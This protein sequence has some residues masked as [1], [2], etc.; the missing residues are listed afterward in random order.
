MASIDKVYKLT[1]INCNGLADRPKRIQVLKWAKKHF[2]G[3]IFLQETHTN[4]KLEGKWRNEAGKQYHLFFSHASSAKCG[5]CIL[6]PKHLL[7]NVIDVISDEEGRL[8][9][10]QLKM[11]NV[12]YTLC[13]VYAP[14]KESQVEQVAFL[15]KLEPYLEKFS[16]TKLLIGGDFNI[17]CNP[18]LDKYKAKD[19]ELPSRASIRLNDLKKQFN[20][21][22]IWRTLNPKLI[23]FTWRRLNPLQQ[24]RLDYWLM[25][26]S[27]IF[28]VKNCEIGLSFR[29]DHNA[30]YID[31]KFGNPQSRGKGLWKMNNSLLKE[32]RYIRCI[33]DLLTNLQADLYLID[34]DRLTWEY[35][36]MCI[37]RETIQ[38]SINRKKRLEQERNLLVFE[39]NTL[40]IKISDSTVI[41]ENDVYLYQSLKKDLDDLE[42]EKINGQ[43]LRSKAQWAEEGERSS[44]F[45]LNLEKHNYDI[46]HITMLLSD[47]GEVIEGSNK[48]QEELLRFYQN[49]YTSPML[50]SEDFTDYLPESVLNELDTKLLDNLISLEECKEALDDLPSGKT[51][52]SD[53]LTK[54]FYLCFWEELGHLFYLSL[55]RSVEV[56]EL[57]IE[58]R[59]GVINLLP[60]ADKDL[61]YIKNW[62]PISI[63]NVDYKIIAKILANRMSPIL[64]QLINEDQTGYVMNRLMGENVRV[65]H[66]LMHC[67]D[68]GIIEGVLMLVDFQKAFDSLSWDFL[69]YT[70]EV[71]GFGLYFRNMVKLLYTNITGSVINNGYCTKFFQL[72]RGIRQ[73]CPVSAYL[74]ILCVELLA[75]KIRA[76][77]TIKGITIKDYTY[78]V[79]QFAD[80]TVIITNSLEG[81]RE[82][83]RVL[84]HFGSVSGLVI[85]KEK[86]ELINLSNKPHSSNTTFGLTW[87]TTPFRYLGIWFSTDPIQMEYKN[88]RH[89]LDKI[90]NLLK[91][92]RQRD[93]SLKGKVTILRS[94]AL[95]QL[96]FPMSL[97]DCPLW[98]MSEANDLFFK[99]LWSDKPDKIKRSTVIRGIE[100]GG[101]KMID[102][103]TM[104]RAMKAKWCVK[105]YADSQKKW[106]NIA[107]TFFDNI[108]M[109]MF[110]NSNY[111][112]STIPNSLPMFYKQCLYALSEVKHVNFKDFRVILSQSLWFNKHIRV[113]GKPVFCQEWYNKGLCH[114]N[115]LIGSDGKFQEPQKIFEKFTIEATNNNVLLFFSLKSAIPKAWKIVLKNDFAY[116]SDLTDFKED[117]MIVC[118]HIERNIYFVGNKDIYWCLIKLKT[119]DIVTSQYMWENDY[120]VTAEN[121]SKYNYAPYTYVRDCKIQSM[122]YKI[123]HNVY[124]C[125]LKLFQYK[126]FSDAKCRDCGIIDNLPHHFYYCKDM[127]IF[128]NSIN[129]WWKQTCQ[130]CSVND[131]LQVL[132]GIIDKSCH[133]PQLNYIILV[134][135]WYV[136]R[137]KYLSQK[138][139]FLEFLCELKTR[140]KVEEKVYNNNGKSLKF[141][142][143]WHETVIML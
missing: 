83:L 134:A 63:L 108:P 22:D 36:K 8:L 103:D 37:R 5:V 121:L 87:C 137:T 51:P 2:K 28:D 139:C 10:I 26:D 127:V 114:I 21:I 33:R 138:C 53:G 74:F 85:N 34:D 73:G 129:N 82:C 19:K 96:L 126:I 68:L 67:A 91:I 113:A 38:Y 109:C 54:E 95:S 77:S 119:K 118:D 14:T 120:N 124:P 140:L 81:I 70:L 46:R 43:I 35:V 13:N 59:R 107:S 32:A 72:Q 56:G 102:I 106:C 98:A 71:C 135:K 48:I 20:L 122:Q 128:W 30:V 111:D 24:S 117:I 61:R 101:L 1:T 97:L 110:I 90:R 39:L 94:L 27:L 47:K 141:L 60:K 6:I 12:I 44:K 88:Y 142:D 52:G 84:R 93:L 17:V 65:I 57:T 130:H 75:C 3:I 31:L 58:Q 55:L 92:W 4:K 29:S 69:Q 105:M 79:L 64:P 25:S 18:Q 115:D 23:R 100:Q 132:L 143:M 125:G 78:N 112:V 49:L 123:L 136:Y 80:D 42:S 45:F 104:A 16:D 131:I 133:K 89:R 62:R 40:E 116:V 7:G 76:N 66:D 41:N 11:N 86:T 15:N 9:I 50:N 99:F